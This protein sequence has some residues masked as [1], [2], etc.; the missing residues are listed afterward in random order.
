MFA[1]DLFVLQSTKNARERCMRNLRLVIIPNEQLPY[2]NKHCNIRLTC[3]IPERIQRNHRA[4]PVIKLAS[5][6]NNSSN[7][8]RCNKQRHVTLHVHILRTR[9]KILQYITRI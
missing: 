4:F 1:T 8:E 3:K 2:V 9:A 6:A 7:K 5:N